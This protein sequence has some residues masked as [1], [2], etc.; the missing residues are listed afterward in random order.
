MRIL[1]ALLIVV[2][3][4]PFMTIE[5]QGGGTDDKA[6][7]WCVSV[8]YPSSEEPTGYQSIIDNADVIDE[9]NPFWYGP[10]LDGTLFMFDGAEDE[11]KLA[12]WR[13]AG[14]KIVPTIATTAASAM[15]E[16]SEIRAFHIG[17]I[18]ALIERMD[19][20]GIDI[21]YEGFAL[22]TRDD[23]SI[24]IE[25]LADTLHANNR[26][27]TM[28]VHAKTADV[29]FYEAATAQD[30][31]RLTSA[32]DIFR[33]MTYDYHNRASIAG[34]IAPLP[35]VND[36]VAYASTLTDLSKVRLGLHFYGYSWRRGNVVSVITWQTVQHWVESFKL[37]ISR[38]SADQE[39]HLELDVTGLPDQSIYVADAQNLQFKLD[40]LLET[41]PE[42]GGVAIWGLGGEDPA[43]WNVLR[44]IGGD[45]MFN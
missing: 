32:V 21:D 42:L 14:I 20:D 39:A 19:Y 3:I 29:A 36:V 11:E 2:L 40:T 31:E 25:E 45:C 7:N 24:F 6:S 23:F 9:V 8:W 1:I 15:I 43:Q 27:L 26:L 22:H 16:D 33:I 18:V 17:E 41:Y 28:A 12:D 10:S 13:E 35:W 37:E 44:E 34:A 38:D 5:A 4:A 30:W